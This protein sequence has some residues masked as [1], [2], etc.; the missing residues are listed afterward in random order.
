MKNP[1]LTHQ[2]HNLFVFAALDK[3]K[4]VTFLDTDS[5]SCPNIKLYSIFIL[6]SG[7]M[8]EPKHRDKYGSSAGYNSTVTMN[9]RGG[10]KAKYDTFARNPND[11][12]PD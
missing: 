9:F 12:V 2:L 3:C 7:A 5:V 11:P 8:G 4:V 6:G 10:D 1:V